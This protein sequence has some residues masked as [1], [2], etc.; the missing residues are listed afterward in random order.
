MFKF[1]QGDNGLAGLNS[2]WIEDA[3]TSL[4]ACPLKAAHG[5][6]GRYTGF[7]KRWKGRAGPSAVMKKVR[8][9]SLK[10]AY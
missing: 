9:I 2:C 1:L 6:R 7:F 3:L 10:D 8:D 5:H 4:Q